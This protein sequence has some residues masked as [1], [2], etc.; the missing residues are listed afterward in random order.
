MVN[1]KRYITKTSIEINNGKY[2]WHKTIVNDY[3]DFV[4]DEIKGRLIVKE[5]LKNKIKLIIS[6]NNKQKEINPDTVFGDKFIDTTIDEKQ[7]KKA[8]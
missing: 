2:Q 4:H 5:N 7:I 1:D 8:S 6:Y 3:I